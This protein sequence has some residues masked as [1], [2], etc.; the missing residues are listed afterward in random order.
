VEQSRAASDQQLDELYREHPEG[1]TAARDRLVKDLRAA[2]ERDEADRVK[3]LRRPTLAAWLINRAALESPA[4]LER[5]STASQDLERAQNLAL[6]GREEGAAEWRAAAA[7]ERDATASVV[8]AAKR[9]ARAAGH[10]PS[11]RALELVGE[12][13]RAA[14][15]DP[16]LRARVLAGRV[17]REQTAATVGTPAAASAGTAS[18]GKRQVAS[19]R[20]HDVGE[21]RREL[22]RLR[23]ELSEAAAQQELSRVQVERAQEALRREKATL[24]ERRRATAALERQLKA[25]ERR[26]QD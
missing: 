23:R 1:F 19:K 26:T 14:T 2:G 15:G 9:L 5:F 25:A 22:R 12:T 16:E 10:P 20:R 21:A 17:E 18:K 7:E 6:E 13:L 3:R 24:S 11:E 4:E 8:D